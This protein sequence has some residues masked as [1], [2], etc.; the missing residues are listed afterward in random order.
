ML[1]RAKLISCA[2]GVSNW[3]LSQ[4]NRSAE[5]LSGLL[6]HVPVYPDDS[7]RKKINIGGRGVVPT[8][9]SIS[10]FTRRSIISS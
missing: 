4:D 9:N 10:H 1:F 6:E 7:G 5:A 2:L 8:Q 3:S